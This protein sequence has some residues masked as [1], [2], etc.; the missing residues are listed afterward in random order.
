[1]AER[2]REN[3]TASAVFDE[4]ASASEPQEEHMT[5]MRHHMLLEM[6]MPSGS[7]G[8]AGISLLHFVP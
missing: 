5:R 7:A 4:M 3:Q 1:M 2:H 8:D 6:L